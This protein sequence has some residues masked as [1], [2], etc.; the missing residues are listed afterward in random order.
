MRIK[1]KSGFINYI[2][3][4]S[5]AIYMLH[6]FFLRHCYGDIILWIQSNVQGHLLT[7][8]AVA[9]LAL[10][11]LVSCILADKILSPCWKLSSKIAERIS[12]TKIG[13]IVA[14]YNQI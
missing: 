2:A 3:R 7:I 11:T 13:Q 5:L 14:N 6:M 1:L 9:V 8:L 12:Q 4:S 10:V